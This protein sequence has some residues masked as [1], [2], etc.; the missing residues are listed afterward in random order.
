M[1]E[2][3]VWPIIALT[4]L[5][6][7]TGPVSAQVKSYKEWKSEKISVAQT[8]VSSLKN[9]LEFRKAKRSAANGTDPNLAQRAQGTF[10]A[11]STSDQMAERLERQLKT[12]LYSLEVAQD[13]SVTDY[14][15]GYLTK[16]QNQ[17][18]AFNEVAGKL[19]PEEVSELMTAYANSVFGVDAGEFSANTPR[20]FKQS[21]K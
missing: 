2:F 7:I 10:E 18:A 20:E 5:V 6:M 17:K 3:K 12:E 8:R 1:R 16:V 4:A 15:A 19:S 9:Q 14:F 11:A 21:S 13:L